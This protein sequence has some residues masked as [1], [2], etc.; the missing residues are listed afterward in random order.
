MVGLTIGVLAPWTEMG[1]GATPVLSSYR[2]TLVKVLDFYPSF[3]NLFIFFI[4]VFVTLY[5]VV[6]PNIGVV[7][8]GQ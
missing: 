7:A 2:Y 5:L 1:G 8:P 3:S 6:A 4:K